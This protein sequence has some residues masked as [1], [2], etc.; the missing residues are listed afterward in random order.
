MLQPLALPA[1]VATQ[2]LAARLSV[3]ASR[4]ADCELLLAW[5]NW[6]A[7]IP[8]DATPVVPSTAV[9][10]ASPILFIV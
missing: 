7:A 3:L 8:A 6:C 4:A 10:M 5:V 9:A 2:Q 1:P